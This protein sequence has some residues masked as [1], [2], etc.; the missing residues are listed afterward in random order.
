MSKKSNSKKVKESI[1]K[2]NLP[3]ATEI[4]IKFIEGN[5]DLI[6]SSNDNL[7]FKTYLLSHLL[8][9]TLTSG[10]IGEFE[11]FNSKIKFEIIDKKLNTDENINDN[12]NFIAN[13]M[14]EINIDNKNIN[15]DKL[16]NEME[17]KLNLDDNSPQNLEE[18]NEE[19]KV[20]LI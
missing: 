2:I 18:L 5:L 1:Q 14:T 11:F 10:Y 17:Q 16:I 13:Q 12:G 4:K 8:H 20:L 6:K 19:D 15:V 9:K 7:L 3:I